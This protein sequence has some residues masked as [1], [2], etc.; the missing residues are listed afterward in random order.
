MAIYHWTPDEQTEPTLF[1]VKVKKQIKLV[2]GME[3]TIFQGILY[4]LY[5]IFRA[6]LYYQLKDGTRVGTENAA[7]LS[8]HKNHPPSDIQLSNDTI[9]WNSPQGT[10]IGT[11]STVDED[12]GESFL[13]GLVDTAGRHFAIRDNQLIVYGFPLSKQVKQYTVVVRSVDMVG[14]YLDKPFTISV[15]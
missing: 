6:D 15:D 8:I 14:A 5:G 11:L 13:Y 9:A 1:P 4:D 7:T 3:I 2:D 12:K 10:V